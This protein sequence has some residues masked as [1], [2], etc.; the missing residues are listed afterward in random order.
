MEKIGEKGKVNNFAET[1]TRVP[2]GKFARVGTHRVK[3]FRDGVGT[4]TIYYVCKNCGMIMFWNVHT[5]AWVLS[6]A[7]GGVVPEIF[8]EDSDPALMSC[9][10][11]IVR[12]VLQ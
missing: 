2:P 8:R 10:D 12:E 4:R 5:R 1:A 3:F 9:A 11:W 6:S 7:N